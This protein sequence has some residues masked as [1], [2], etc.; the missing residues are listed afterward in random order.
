MRKVTDWTLWRGRPLLK[1]KGTSRNTL[2]AQPSE[3]MNGDIPLGYSGQTTLRRE[4]CDS[5]P[6]TLVTN[7]EQRIAVQRSKLFLQ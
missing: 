3:E 6:E 2:Q 7:Y 5:T 1:E 4:Q